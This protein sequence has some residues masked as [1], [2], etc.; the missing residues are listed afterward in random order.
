MPFKLLVLEDEPDIRE[1]L[2]ITLVKAGYQVTLVGRVHE[3]L[4]QIGL[5]VPDLFMLDWMLPDQSG[6]Y[7]LRKIRSQ[8]AFVKTPIMMLTAR[9]AENDKVMAF[10][11]GA[12]DYLTKPFSPRELTVRVGALLRR[13]MPADEEKIQVLGDAHICHNTFTV[14]VNEIHL[15]LQPME[16]RFLQFLLTRP[17]WIFTR[18]KLIE[19]VWGSRANIDERTVDAHIMRL[20]KTLHPIS[21]SLKIETVRGEGY[22]LTSVTG[23]QA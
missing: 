6:L 12:D 20:R 1:L 16:F 19:S 4:Y 15:K 9:S 22:R 21:H 23:D 17:N 5:Q 11:S 18:S 8:E 13:A 7:L 10:E 3:A 2:N 14:K